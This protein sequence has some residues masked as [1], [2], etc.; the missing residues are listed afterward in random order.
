MTEVGMPEY[1][2]GLFQT[3]AERLRARKGAVAAASDAYGPGSIAVVSIGRA[4]DRIYPS[5]PD[6]GAIFTEDQINRLVDAMPIAYNSDEFDPWVVI[7]EIFVYNDPM[8][9]GGY[10]CDRLVEYV[11]ADALPTKAQ[12]DRLLV[13]LT[14]VFDPDLYQSEDGFRLMLY[15]AAGIE[16]E[17]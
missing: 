17:G 15:R 1:A 9:K 12:I 7:R 4:F 8:Q 3:E 6:T 2:Q 14:K 11:R 16:G 5:Q 10:G 13:E